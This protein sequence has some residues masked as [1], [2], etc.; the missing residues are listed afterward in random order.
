MEKMLLNSETFVT[1]KTV[2]LSATSISFFK[3]AV[4]KVA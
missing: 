4:E 2:F 3:T 1:N